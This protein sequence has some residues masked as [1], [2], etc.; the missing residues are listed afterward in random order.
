MKDS[1][2]IFALINVRA[3]LYFDRMVHVREIASP[4]LLVQ[5]VANL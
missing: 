1:L 3:Q 5:A 4:H 2:Y